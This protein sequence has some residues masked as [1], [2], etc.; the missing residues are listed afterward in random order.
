MTNI[1]RF[2]AEFFGAPLDTDSFESDFQTSPNVLQLVPTNPR[3]WALHITNTGA[4]L[5]VYSRL[6]TVTLTTGVMLAPGD[7]QSLYWYNEFREIERAIY[8]I[9]D[10]FTPTLHLRELV[11]N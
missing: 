6:N 10:S 11:F 2:I 5:A 7:T 9:G 8:V 4:G 3:R 1:A